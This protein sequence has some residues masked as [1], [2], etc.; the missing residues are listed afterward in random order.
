[1][2][3]SET[4]LIANSAFA[5]T[6]N[7]TA[8]NSCTLSSESG[9]Q[10][11]NYLK[12]LTG[13]ENNPEARSDAMTVVASTKYRLSFYYKDTGS[14]SD[15]PA[16]S[17][18][19]AS[20]T[21]YIV[22]GQA[23]TSSI[24]TSSW[25][26]QEHEFSTPSG[27]TSLKVYLRHTGSSGDSSYSGFDTVSLDQLGIWH[28]VTGSMYY[29]GVNAHPISINSVSANTEVFYTDDWSAKIVGI[30]STGF[31]TADSEPT[32]PQVPL[33][34]YNEKMVFDGVDNVVPLSTNDLSSDMT[35]CAWV[36]TE[37]KASTQFIAGKWGSSNGWYI[38]L[39]TSGYLKF[40][41]NSSGINATGT[42]DLSDGKVHHIACVYDAGT[43]AKVYVD[44][45]LQATTTS[46]VPGN[47]SNT[48]QA[49]RVGLESNNANPF[50]GI[51]DEVS[52]WNTALSETEI[53]SL[54]NDGIAL[55][56]T[57]HSKADTN[58]LGYWRNDGIS[59]WADR[60][61]I[62]AINFDGT[63]DYIVTGSNVGI[64]GS[65][66]YSMNCWFNLN[67]YGSYPVLMGSG[68][69][70]GYNENSLLIRTDNNT[71]GWG[72]QIG[73]NDFANP[74]G[75]TISLNTW[76]MTTFT[77]NGSDTI[78]IY[79]N[80]VLDGTNSVSSIN[81][82]NSVLYIGK[83]SNGLFLNGQ[84]S[85]CA[86][87][88]SELSA[89]DILGIYN[90]GRKNADLS[91]SYPTNLTGY[92]LLNPIHSSPDVTGSNGIEDRSTNSNHG[93]QNGGVSFLGAND[94]TPAGTPESIIV[95]EGL[96]S[97][98]DGLGFPFKN[99]DRD[100]LRLSENASEYIQIDDSDVFT[101][102][103]SSGDSPFS[104]ETWVKMEDA[105]SFPIISKGFYNTDFEWLLWTYSDDK[106]RF[107][108]GDESVSNCYIG[109]GYN[110]ALT[111]LEGTW[112]HIVATYNASGAS[113]G[114]K[115][116]LNGDSTAVDDINDQ[117]NEG[118]Y[119]SMENLASPVYIG[120]YGTTY[121]KGL[122]DEVRIYNKVLSSTEISK[123]YKH[124]KGKHKN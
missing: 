12:V 88:S 43:S 113:S 123:N 8:G 1:M 63:D 62:Q 39:L 6:S 32:I 5:N 92:W 17:I 31:A 53:M 95:R 16:F 118:S 87:Y 25:V 29:D 28:S 34:R 11:G 60:N 36:S 59:S 54:F 48:A 111:S 78:K 96:N 2:Q 82:T 94:G 124:G 10:S 65:N 61:D 90:L 109:R 101:F 52:E 112:I 69:I 99:D 115:L 3:F 46:S 4:N 79:I 37:T 83:R 119:V 89:D 47:L 77:F 49:L 85:Q 81:I 105:T 107:A 35:I 13:V 33:L 75:A 20:N 19:D 26:L 93:T 74:D 73:A 27:C 84:M 22:N 102:G 44:G 58:L 110:T 55:D 57:T 9:G 23:V 15:I 91:V 40:T 117:S 7:W 50:K 42:T 72:N 86:V 56:A 114:V 45:V 80:G 98:K 68:A 108:L 14:S 70:T 97:N 71:V 21:A 122:I 76:Y 41:I 18:Y 30:S 51:I 116:Y 67:A 24:S 106:L 38:R 103:N 121:A 120:K 66:A 100:V 64:S 104:I